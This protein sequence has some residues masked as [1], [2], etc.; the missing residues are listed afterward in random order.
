[1][2]KA[3]HKQFVHNHLEMIF[4]TIKHSN[5]SER[6]VRYFAPCL[7]AVIPFCPAAIVGVCHWSRLLCLIPFGFGD[8][9][10]RECHKAGYGPKVKGLFWT[11]QGN[12]CSR[13]ASIA[14]DHFP[15]SFRPSSLSLSLSFALSLS[16][17]PSLSLSPSHTSM[18]VDML[19]SQDKSEADVERI[20]AT[21]LLCYGYVCFHSPPTWVHSSP[22][23]S[24]L[25]PKTHGHIVPQAL[26][27]L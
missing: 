9:K 26:I 10:V 14:H 18:F 23:F 17:L 24:H 2:R 16:L 12:G 19:C 25:L 20:K 27:W 13:F 21:V 15:F 8:W 6:E 5:Q 3:T 7:S 4:S 22:H 1:M 11:H